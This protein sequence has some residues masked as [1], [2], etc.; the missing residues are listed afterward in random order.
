MVM[1]GT[2]LEPGAGE[3]TGGHTPAAHGRKPLARSPAA[4][5]CFRGFFFIFLAILSISF[6]EP[7]KALLGICWLNNR[8]SP[9]SSSRAQP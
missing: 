2:V 6:H 5:S 1:A 3:P 9:L 8:P 7:S 4:P